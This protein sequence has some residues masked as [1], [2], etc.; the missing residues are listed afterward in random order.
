MKPMVAWPPGVKLVAV[1]HEPWCFGLSGVEMH[2]AACAVIFS[3][4]VGELAPGC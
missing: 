2:E 1:G 4:E 3:G